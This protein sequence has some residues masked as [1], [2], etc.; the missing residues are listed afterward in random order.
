MPLE[1]AQQFPLVKNTL[2]GHLSVMQATAQN[3][4]PNSTDERPGFFLKGPLIA[5]IQIALIIGALLLILLEALGRLSGSSGSAS[6]GILPGLA[7]LLLALLVLRGFRL[8]RRDQA[9]IL[10]SGQKYLGTIRGGGLVWTNPFV[11]RRKLSL[12]THQT[13]VQHT[14]DGTRSLTANVSW[15]VTDTAKALQLSDH[16]DQAV[17][18]V[19]YQTLTETGSNDDRERF[20]SLLEQN[21]GRIGATVRQAELQSGRVAL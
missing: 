9:L 18:Q 14:V 15:Q 11:S 19:I 4:P 16:Y 1:G 12:Q 5:I 8:M 13:T 7:L 20:K 6:A 10:Y 17:Q 2:S 21:L 3:V